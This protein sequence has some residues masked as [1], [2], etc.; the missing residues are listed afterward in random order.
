MRHSSPRSVLLPLHS[1]RAWGHAGTNVGT[2]THSLGLR[3]VRAAGVHSADAYLEV[4][5]WVTQCGLQGTNF[6][7]PLLRFYVCIQQLFLYATAHT[8]GREFKGKQDAISV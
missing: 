6:L 8:Q 2:S 5:L 1:R 7:T 3:S 4:A